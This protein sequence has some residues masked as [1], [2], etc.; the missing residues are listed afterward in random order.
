ML[1]LPDSFKKI[2]KSYKWENCREGCT[3]FKDPRTQ[4]GR[5]SWWRGKC[6]HQPSWKSFL[7]GNLLLPASQNHNKTFMRH[8]R[9][10]LSYQVPLIVC[11]CIMTP[12]P[13][14][15]SLIAL[16]FCTVCSKVELF[17]GLYLLQIPLPQLNFSTQG[18]SVSL[19]CR[20]MS[21]PL[22]DQV[23]V[24]VDDCWKSP[25]ET[26]SWWNNK[27]CTCCAEWAPV[28]F[29]SFVGRKLCNTRENIEGV[30]FTDP[31]V[32]HPDML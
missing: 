25:K 32:F 20:V 18:L 11:Q 24:V 23:V 30:L 14:H 29:T 28:D 10:Q 8:S 9:L 31:V 21:L 3:H 26:V 16:F 6:R 15:V 7:P 12:N 4:N 5:G 27:S 1:S 13:D 17:W 19:H 22:R 2:Y